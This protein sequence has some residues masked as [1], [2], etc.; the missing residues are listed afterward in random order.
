MFDTV[1]CVV[2]PGIVR[3]VNVSNVFQHCW[4]CVMLDGIPGIVSACWYC[5]YG[6]QHCWYVLYIVNIVSID[7]IVL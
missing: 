1:Y 5:E 3:F 2:G 7:G 4:Y 6:C